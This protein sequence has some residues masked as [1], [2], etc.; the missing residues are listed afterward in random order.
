MKV[1]VV[2]LREYVNMVTADRQEAEAKA[3]EGLAYTDATESEFRKDRWDHRELLHYRS[4]RTGRW[5]KTDYSITT[6]ELS[7]LPAGA[8]QAGS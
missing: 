8:E 2:S 6:M 4:P 5:N 1:Y 7:G 3:R